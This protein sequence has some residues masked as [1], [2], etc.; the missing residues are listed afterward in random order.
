ME[1]HYVKKV[2]RLYAI[3]SARQLIT[4]FDTLIISY[5]LESSEIEKTIIFNKLINMLTCD[6]NISYIGSDDVSIDVKTTEEFLELLNY[7]SNQYFERTNVTN[8]IVDKYSSNKNNEFDCDC[9]K[10][11]L[12]TLEIKANQF[13]ITGRQN[14]NN[15]NITVTDDFYEI[16]EESCDQ[17]KIKH[18]RYKVV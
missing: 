7:L 5:A 8:F 10:H 2:N 4:I 15:V 16:I 11:R 1:K 13:I 18:I 6:F 14:F 3:E 17:F 12:R 9:L